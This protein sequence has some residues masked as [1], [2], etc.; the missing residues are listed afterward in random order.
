[1]RHPEGSMGSQA[2]LE[3]SNGAF[4]YSSG[5]KDWGGAQETV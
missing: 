3:D 5:E 4:S 1:M 2:A